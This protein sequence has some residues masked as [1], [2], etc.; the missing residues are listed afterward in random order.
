MPKA[1][2]ELEFDGRIFWYVH[3]FDPAD[4]VCCEPGC[5]K[6]IDEDDVPLILWK[7]K[8]R[9]CRMSRLHTACAE[10]IGLFRAMKG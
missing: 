9:D 4:D 7:G 8:G 3:A 1:A 5:R 2:P 6:P 10:R